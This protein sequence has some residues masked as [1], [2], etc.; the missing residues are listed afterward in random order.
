MT[1]LEHALSCLF[2]YY[3]LNAIRIISVYKQ[4]TTDRAVSVRDIEVR[5]SNT[6]W[7]AKLS[8]KLGLT[9]P[10]TFEKKKYYYLN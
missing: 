6:K 4:L 7:V 2:E 5:G 1:A 8:G 10:P 3:D 9:T